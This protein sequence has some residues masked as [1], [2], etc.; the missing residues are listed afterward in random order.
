MKKYTRTLLRGTTIS[1]LTSLTAM[2]VMSADENPFQLREVPRPTTNELRLAHGM[3]GACGGNREGRCGSMMNGMMM[4]GA[5]PQAL[6]PV[7][8]PEPD[9]AGSKL[10]TK[11]C[12]QCHGLPSPKQHSAAGWPTT[13]A[14]MNT[15]MQWMSRNNSPMNVEAPSEEELTTL[16]SY[17]EKHALTIEDTTALSKKPAKQ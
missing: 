5:M 6:D 3:C 2:P 11:Y 10:V 17:L 14:R 7:Q 8:L 16:T 9:T 15:R 4:G 12:T 1:L 13:V